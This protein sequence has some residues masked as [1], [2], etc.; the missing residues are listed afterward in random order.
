[1]F[2]EAGGSVFVDGGGFLGIGTSALVGV[3]CKGRD[4]EGLGEG[5]MKQERLGIRTRCAVL[6]LL[7][8]LKVLADAVLK[9]TLAQQSI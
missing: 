1:M 6:D 9:V 3:Q 5:E 2:N 8:L 7:D 4:N